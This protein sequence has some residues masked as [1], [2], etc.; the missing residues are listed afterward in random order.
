MKG[1]TIGRGCWGRGRRVGPK[2]RGQQGAEG[3]A[4][5]D[6]AQAEGLQDRFEVLLLQDILKL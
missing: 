2:G 3:G 5:G 4:E 1:G 6:S